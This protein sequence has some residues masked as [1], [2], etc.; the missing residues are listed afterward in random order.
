MAKHLPNRNIMDFGFS[1]NLNPGSWNAREHALVIVA[2][3]GSSYTA[4]GLGPLSTMKLYYGKKVGAE[5]AILFLITTQLLGYGF[6]GLY[7]DASSDL[8]RYTTRASF[9][10]SAC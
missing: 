10:S 9:P 7:R 5:W 2:F 1:C 3:W 8:R 4:G 6:A